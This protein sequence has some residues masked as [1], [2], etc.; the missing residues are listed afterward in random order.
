MPLSRPWGRGLPGHI[1]LWVDRVLRRWSYN[2]HLY[3][4]VRKTADSLFRSPGRQRSL[5][6][7]NRFT[8]K[9]LCLSLMTVGGLHA[10]HSDFLEDIALY[11]SRVL[12]RRWSWNGCSLVGKTM[13]IYCSGV[14]E[15][16]GSP[17]QWELYSEYG[18][19]MSIPGWHWGILHFHCSC[20][21]SKWQFYLEDGLEVGVCQ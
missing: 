3:L 17:S 4:T 19:E 16:Q 14:F 2:S 15:W 18:L 12:C 1:S 21:K 11:I 8:W 5:N 7:N 9:I 6:Q 20:L 10:H 13:H